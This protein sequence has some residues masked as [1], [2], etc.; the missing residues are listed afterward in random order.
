[1]NE[2]IVIFVEDEDYCIILIKINSNLIFEGLLQYSS[3][4]FVLEG[5]VAPL[6]EFLISIQLDEVIRKY[7]HRLIPYPSSIFVFFIA[8][9][10]IP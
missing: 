7:P 8:P 9:P 3:Y 10:K 5:K 4:V 1:M 2:S 6:K